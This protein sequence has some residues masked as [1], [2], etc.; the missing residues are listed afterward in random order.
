MV[1]YT[2][3]SPLGDSTSAQTARNGSKVFAFEPNPHAF[4]VL[5]KRF[6]NSLNVECIQAGVH[7]KNGTM[8][9][10]FHENAKDDQV[11]WSTGSSI[12]AG[13]SNISKQDYVEVTAIDFCEFINEQNR[14]I[15]LVKMDIE[16]A[17]CEIL[18]K[19]LNTEIIHKIDHM[20][21]ERH[22]H[23]IPELQGAMEIIEKTLLK[24]N[25]KNVYLNWI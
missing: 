20:F 14:R 9:L 7:H 8:R 11:L 5:Q 6:V 24:K 23:K 16:G 2:I 15:R 17:E 1:P 22:D 10:Y 21:V 4:D 19:I 18:M 12:L 3:I 25:I 13:K